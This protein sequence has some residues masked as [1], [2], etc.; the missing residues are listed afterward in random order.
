MECYRKSNDSGQIDLPLFCKALDSYAQGENLGLQSLY[1]VSSYRK[2][3]RKSLSFKIERG[4]REDGSGLFYQ[5]CEILK[6]LVLSGLAHLAALLRRGHFFVVCYLGSGQK[7]LRCHRRQLLGETVLLLV[8]RFSD[9]PE[10]S[11]KVRQKIRH[12]SKIW[13]RKASFRTK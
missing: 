9:G 8:K 4:E 5:G 12:S 2:M 11:Q 3:F 1:N 13:T 7:R 10:K 6:V